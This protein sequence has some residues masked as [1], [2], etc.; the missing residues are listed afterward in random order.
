MRSM[1]SRSDILSVNVLFGRNLAFAPLNMSIFCMFALVF[2]CAMIWV[3]PANSGLPPTRS[4]LAFVLM[5]VA[6]GLSLTA[7]TE[8]RIGW[9][10]PRRLRVD[11]DGA[12]VAH[13]RHRVAAAPLHHVQDVPDVQRLHLDGL[14]LL[15]CTLI[16]G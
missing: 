14:A 11:Q 12:L 1:P 15:W 8:S 13:E 6:T 16:P 3:T 5:I 2:S 4:G 7:A 10:P 9:A